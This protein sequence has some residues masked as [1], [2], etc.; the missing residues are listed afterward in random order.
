MFVSEAPGKSAGNNASENHRAAAFGPALCSEETTTFNSYYGKRQTQALAFTETMDTSLYPQQVSASLALSFLFSSLL[1]LFI[2]L[3][4]LFSSFEFSPA[5]F[6]CVCLSLCPCGNRTASGKLRGLVWWKN[7]SYL[8]GQGRPQL[9]WPYYGSVCECWRD[10]W[11]L[12]CVCLR[13]VWEQVCV[14]V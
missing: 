13:V 8:F 5:L 14:C 3:L 10:L 9:T 1:S 7:S 2:F 4:L 11:R 6:L 12:V